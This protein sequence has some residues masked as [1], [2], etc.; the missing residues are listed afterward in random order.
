MTINAQH[1]QEETLD[2]VYRL[3]QLLEE[4]G[5]HPILKGKLCM[6]GGTAINIFM[7]DVPRL[8][9]DIDLS[10][11]GAADRKVM[12][13]ERPSIEKALSEVVTLAGYNATGGSG[14]HAGRT[15][16]LNYKGDWGPDQIKI[17]LIYLNRVPLLPTQYIPSSINP[18]QQV[19]TFS[20]LELIG[21]K[22]K[23][24]YD[25]V[26]LRD[27][28]DIANLKLYLDDFLANNPNQKDLCFKLMTFH[29]SLS[30]HFPLPLEERVA[31]KFSN[32]KNELLS[33]VYPML[34]NGEQPSLESLIK[35][36]EDFIGNYVL[37]QDKQAERYLELFAQAT[38]Q[39]QLLFAD[40]PRT[41][42]AA[43][44]HPGALWK[45][46]NLEKLND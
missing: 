14:D 8:S 32:R 17:D 26:A 11:I 1:F 24:L 41:L 21:G 10:Y 30:H 40:Y 31:Q 35:T 16:H 34:R 29:A 9:V 44:I 22:L 37:P 27:L 28:Y 19:H 36:A 15:Y 33:Q 4:I 2:K 43:Q 6:H 13:V 5:R 46:A 3:L 7:L 25:R 23:A 39:P 20:N 12:L 42:S 18:E 38:Y 45:L